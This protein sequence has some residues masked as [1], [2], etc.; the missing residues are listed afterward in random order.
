M[1]LRANNVISFA[2]LL[3]PC[4]FVFHFEIS[5]CKAKMLFIIANPH[6][7]LILVVNGLMGVRDVKDHLYS[8]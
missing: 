6:W 3:L 8:H 5:G 1:K 7:H 4:S 2:L